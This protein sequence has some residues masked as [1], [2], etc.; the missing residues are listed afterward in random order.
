MIDATRIL[1]ALR[2]NGLQNPISNAVNA[3]L[4]QII[5]PTI[6]NM[7]TAA[8][9]QALIAGVEAPTAGAIT[10]AHDAMVSAISAGNALIT[11]TNTLS[12]V[13]LSTNT[14]LAIIARTVNAARKI[15]ADNSCSMIHLSFGSLQKSSELITDTQNVISKINETLNNLVQDLSQKVADIT[16]YATKIVS[17]I[18]SD[19]TAFVTAQQTIIQHSLAVS[20]V[21]LYDDPCLTAVMDQIV[22]PTLQIEILKERNKAV[23]SFKKSHGL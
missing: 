5:V 19:V 7:I 9:A 23:E 21:G 20:L 8:A 3:Q 15:G 12:G 11:H 18:A 6:P 4:A 13:D 22:K 1:D 2:Q 10:S 16:S 14:N 17:Q